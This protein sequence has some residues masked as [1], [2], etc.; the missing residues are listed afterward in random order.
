MINVKITDV[1]YNIIEDEF[2]ITIQYKNGFYYGTL[3]RN[4]SGVK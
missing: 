4:K 1:D 3:E 2:E